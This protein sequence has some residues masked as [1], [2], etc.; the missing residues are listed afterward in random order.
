MDD[1][2]ENIDDHNPNKNCKILIEFVDMIADMLNN[3]K[4]NPIITGLFI[5]GKKL[6][7]PLAFITQYYFAGLEII[8]LNSTD[9]FILK[10]QN[11]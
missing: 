3:K 2:Y 10:I 7:I 9:S 8:I 6:N 11:K 4:L 5:R 1:I